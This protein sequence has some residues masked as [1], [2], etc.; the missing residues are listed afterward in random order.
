VLIEQL[1]AAP[2]TPIKE[3]PD[4]SAA[5]V[6]KVVNADNG[7]PK[8]TL[9]ADGENQK[10]REVLSDAEILLNGSTVTLDDITPGDAVT[11]QTDAKGR[12]TR[13]DATRQRTGIV[14]SAG[15]GKVEIT[16]DFTDRQSYELAPNAKVLLNRQDAILDDLQ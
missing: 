12:I 14:F 8:L 15:N 11:I 5:Q 4:G 3:A 10:L 2:D 7:K 6:L 1:F 16:T 9:T 13:V